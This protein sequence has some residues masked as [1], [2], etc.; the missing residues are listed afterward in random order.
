MWESTDQPDIGALLLIETRREENIGEAKRARTG[1]TSSC[2]FCFP[3][4]CHVKPTIFEK[5]P[6]T[7]GSAQLFAN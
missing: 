5:R 2:P 4:A 6:D 1:K 3:V 7:S